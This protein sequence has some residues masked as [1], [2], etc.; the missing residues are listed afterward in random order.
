MPQKILIDFIHEVGLRPDEIDE[1]LQRCPILSQGPWS[2]TGFLFEIRLDGGD[3]G[4]AIASKL[5]RLNAHRLSNDS[6]G[7]IVGFDF[8]FAEGR[9]VKTLRGKLASVYNRSKVERAFDVAG[10]NALALWDGFETLCAMS[11]SFAD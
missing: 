2:L 1:L 10:A 9:G 6:I 3:D 4:N 11:V 5:L 8:S 7:E